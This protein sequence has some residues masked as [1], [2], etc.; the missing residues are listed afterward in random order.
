MDK[1][2]T[3]SGDV[4]DLD[5]LRR[6]FRFVTPYSSQFYWLVFLTV[7]VAFL[8]PALP[9]LVQT[10]IDDYILKGD[11]PG[12]VTIVID[13]DRSAG[14]AGNHPVLPH[15]RIGPVGPERDP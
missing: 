14:G 10:A 15:L 13:I 9:V 11:Y 5:I 12:L 3:S 7:A 2:K 6:I 8:G 1:E 4:V